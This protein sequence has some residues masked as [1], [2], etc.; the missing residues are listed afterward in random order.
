M[1]K[2]LE[3]LFQEG[4]SKNKEAG[5]KIMSSSECYTVNEL[6]KYFGV[7]PKTIYRRLWAKQIPA[8]KVGRTWRI[9]KKDVIWLKT[10][11]FSMTFSVPPSRFCYLLQGGRG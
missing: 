4:V 1:S 9:S 7:N 2:F 8:Y 6:A 5:G 3:S 10:I 11:I